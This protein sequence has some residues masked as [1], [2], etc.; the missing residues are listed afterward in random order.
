VP[1]IRLLPL[2]LAAALRV[3][4]AA[5]G[6]RTHVPRGWMGVVATDTSLLSDPALWGAETAVMRRNGVQSVRVPGYWYALEPAQGSFDLRALDALVEGAARRRLR[7]LPTLL[8]TPHWASRSG[9]PNA[10]PDD[11]AVIGPVLT[12]L[13]G[14]Y[15]PAGSFWAEHPGLP[16]VPIRAWQIWNEPE[17]GQY[18]DPPK[19]GAWATTYVALLRAARRALRAA[20][21]HARVVL[22]GLPNDSWNL[23]RRIHRAGGAGQFDV[24]AVHAYTSSPRNV[25]RILRRDRRE[26]D[27][28]RGRSVELLV[29]EMGWSS[30]AHRAHTEDYVTWNTTERGQA[31]RVPQ[32]YRA[33]AAVRRKLRVSG[34]YWY[35]WY[36][37]ERPASEH[38]ED[39]TGLRRQRADGRIV[40]K[41]ALRAYR[42]V[43]RRLER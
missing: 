41:P 18:W 12:A 39:Y 26:L 13:V 43:A 42:S 21:R 27:R 23:L 36:T 34:A 31:R 22:A 29:T 20:D 37:P 9:T 3:P 19:P 2:V 15:G 32:V 28:H 1:R 11:P 35:S 16:R 4:A 25:V 40:S 14:R 24:A 7:L 5:A 17:L 33:V 6:A 30:G 8:G 38:W 10:V